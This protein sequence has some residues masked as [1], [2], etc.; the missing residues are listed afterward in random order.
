MDIVSSCV[1]Y[2]VHSMVELYAILQAE[3][4]VLAVGPLVANHFGARFA[5]LAWSGAGI[6]KRGAPLYT[7]DHHT[8]QPYGL[9]R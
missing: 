1:I 2:L 6:L 4:A 8:V 5:L 7:I 9:L 3:D